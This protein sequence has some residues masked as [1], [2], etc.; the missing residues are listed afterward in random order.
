MHELRR[1]GFHALDAAGLLVTGSQIQAAERS[2][3]EVC[4]NAQQ[5]ARQQ[6]EA[7]RESLL[8]NILFQDTGGNP[9]G[10]TRT[11]QQA[12]ARSPDKSKDGWPRGEQ[13][14][15]KRYIRA[16][17][18]RH[19]QCHTKPIGI[20]CSLLTASYN[21]VEQLVLF[22]PAGLNAETVSPGR[23]CPTAG[24]G[25]RSTHGQRLSAELADITTLDI[26]AIVNAA[27]QSLLGGVA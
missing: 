5:S 25:G 3:E 19:F 14:P 16:R 15:V 23:R 7:D 11:S 13:P 8:S 18:E 17:G 4:N 9:S 12:R 1:P 24:A 20:R 6:Q 2:P 21:V 26:D 10:N 27:N 22:L